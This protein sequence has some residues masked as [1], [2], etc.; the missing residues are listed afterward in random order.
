MERK[1]YALR[2]G[3]ARPPASGL[4]NQEEEKEDET[5]ATEMTGREDQETKRTPGTPS[6]SEALPR[7]C[8]PHENPWGHIASFKHDSKLQST[9]GI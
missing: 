8:Q 2:S 3:G 4:P 6:G 9:R 5:N 7:F 1:K